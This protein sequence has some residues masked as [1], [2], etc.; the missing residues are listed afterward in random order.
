MATANASFDLDEALC[1]TENAANLSFDLDVAL[2]LQEISHHQTTPAN[3]SPQVVV[4][5]D[6]RHHNHMPT[7]I[8]ATEDDEV[9]IFCMEGF[10]S[11]RIGGKQTPCG[12]VYHA[13]CISSWLSYSNRCP[14]CRCHISGEE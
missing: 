2:T 6:H 14:L 3:N 5:A 9:C 4:P 12:H 13:A 10:E 7:T 8:P 1:L 11:S